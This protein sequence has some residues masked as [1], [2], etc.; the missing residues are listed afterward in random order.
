MKFFVILAQRSHYFEVILG[1]FRTEEIGQYQKSHLIEVQPYNDIKGK[2]NFKVMFRTVSAPLQHE[3][4]AGKDKERNL[5]P[6][7]K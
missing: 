4:I 2:K 6:H 1:Q 7:L 5:S 3:K